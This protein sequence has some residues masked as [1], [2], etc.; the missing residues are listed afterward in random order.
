MGWNVKGRRQVYMARTRGYL[1]HHPVSI[2]HA[3]ASSATPPS[4]L[5]NIK[6]TTALNGIMV[7]VRMTIIIN[8]SDIYWS[9]W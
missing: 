3:G 9:L 6:H 7:R 2:L 8:I 4:D 1:L 5:L